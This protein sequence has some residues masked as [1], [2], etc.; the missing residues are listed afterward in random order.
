MLEYRH[1]QLITRRWRKG[2]RQMRAI[3]WLCAAHHCLEDLHRWITPRKPGAISTLQ[4]STAFLYLG[5]GDTEAGFGSGRRAYEGC[6]TALSSMLQLTLLL[7]RS[8]FNISPIDAETPS[9]L[10]GR[11]QLS[12]ADRAREAPRFQ[13]SQQEIATSERVVIC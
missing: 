5:F 10:T 6:R 12:S 7:L 11:R 1:A 8:G 13:H 4:V 9:C 3:M 2:T